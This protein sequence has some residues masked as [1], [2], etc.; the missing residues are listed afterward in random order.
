MTY[1]EEAQRTEAI[2]ASVSLTSG[3]VNELCNAASTRASKLAPRVAY[4]ALESGCTMAAS[5]VAALGP[6]Q[7][8]AYRLQALAYELNRLT[9][10]DYRKLCTENVPAHELRA[11][12]VIALAG[13]ALTVVSTERARFA[14]YL[15]RFS[16]DVHEL[17]R[18]YRSCEDVSYSWVGYALYVH[19]DAPSVVRIRPEADVTAAY[20]EVLHAQIRAQRV[21]IAQLPEHCDCGDA[22]IGCGGCRESDACQ[23]PRCTGVPMTRG[24]L[25][26]V[27]TRRERAE[28]YELEQTTA[29]ALRIL[30]ELAGGEEAARIIADGHSYGRTTLE[31]VAQLLMLEEN[32]YASDG[33]G[34]GLAVIVCDDC[35]R[36]TLALADLTDRKMVHGLDYFRIAELEDGDVPMVADDWRD[37]A[38]ITVR[39]NDGGFVWVA[40]WLTEA[41]AIAE[42]DAW[43]SENGEH[44]EDCDCESCAADGGR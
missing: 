32:D 13:H 28:R 27:R 43:E 33:M 37:V 22:C 30:P 1:Y 4:D 17:A 12:D 7:L 36:M 3:E 39:W 8:A 29:Q 25:S 9:E 10:D 11:G 21:P 34:S 15:I 41:G 23:C 44:A 14:G 26:D 38:A 6:R 16:E 19:D 20:W 31:E 2:A 40:T 5:Y 18:K 42:R 35:V 24:Q